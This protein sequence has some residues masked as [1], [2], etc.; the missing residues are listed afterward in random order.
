MGQAKLTF[1]GS[2]TEYYYVSFD[3]N[4]GSA[5]PTQM[6]APRQKAVQPTAP[7]KSGKAFDCWKLNGSEYNFATAVNGDITLVAEWI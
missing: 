5:V 3:S 1:T 2:D 6:V 4:G 7:T